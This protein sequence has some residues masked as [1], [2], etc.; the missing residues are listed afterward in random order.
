MRLGR[1]L[2]ATATDRIAAGECQRLP[3]LNPRLKS[4][5][6][7]DQHVDRIVGRLGSHGSLQK[8]IEGACGGS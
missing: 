3:E 2:P 8:Q 1:S 7:R 6:T 4:L 5:E